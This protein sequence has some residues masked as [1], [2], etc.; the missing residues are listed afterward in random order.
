M[1]INKNM[2]LGM[3]YKA[4]MVSNAI[5]MLY[6]GQPAQT[7]VR[8]D[9]LAKEGFERNV[10]VYRCV[11]ATARSAASIPILLYQKK[12]KELVEI[13]QH[14]LLELLNKPNN[15]ESAIDF[16]EKLIA[17]LLLSGNAYM[18]MNGPNRGAPTELWSWRP[19]RVT[20]VPGGDYIRAFRYS[21]SGKET[22]IPYEKIVHSKFFAPLDDFYGMGP[23]QVARQTI[24][25]DNATAEWNTSLTQNHAAPSGFLKTAS[26]LSEPQYNR[27]KMM[28]RK[29]F[30]GKQNAGKA[31][32][33]EGGLEWQQLGL[34]P[35]DMDFINS[36]KM[37]REEICAVFG[38]PP[39]IVG[40][41]DNSTYSNYQEARTAFYMETV[42]PTLE[43]LISG[44]NHK[45]APLFGDNL[46]ISYDID[47]IEAL[48]EISDTKWT[49]L[50]GMKDILTVNEIREAIGYEAID[51][52]N[53]R[54]VPVGV[55]PEGED[56][57]EAPVI[58]EPADD[59][60]AE[61]DPMKRASAIFTK[62]AADIEQKAS[63]ARYVAEIERRRTGYIKSAENLVKKR[64]IAEQKVVLSAF[65]KDGESGA[66]KAVNQ[67]KREWEK[68]LTAAWLA[69]SEAFAEANYSR[70][71][72]Q[73][74]AKG[75]VHEKKFIFEEEF[76]EILAFMHEY[77]S[78]Q[79]AEA[80]VLISTFSIERLKAVIGDSVAAG[81][82]IQQTA[83]RIEELYSEEFGKARA[84]TIARTE[85]ISAANYGN[86][87][88]AKATGLDLEKKWISVG[89]KRSRDS[90]KTAN[91]QTR[92]MDEPYDIGGA[93]A[94]YPGDPSLPAKE[95]IKC[96]CAER[97]DV[98]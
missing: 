83:K 59:P 31:H 35:K 5:L 48:Q 55:Y 27:L 58:E 33:L 51:G 17:F 75:K 20:I 22:D 53:V 39:Q 86:R 44:W 9:K 81:E 63:D 43:K 64:F 37:T 24:D 13:E 4:S 90:H 25:M 72:E 7:P 8:F 23:I 95:R 30:G 73:A 84:L 28:I 32:L 68:T 26:S 97:H 50:G 71:A 47:R 78:E 11:M 82:T 88:G 52:G 69:A 36:R 14:P 3:Q 46:V 18:E 34:S 98:I 77:I 12:G 16:R 54:Y 92:P 49:R 61:E 57:P 62:A 2:L 76:P 67:Q 87:M 60:A 80:V 45:L 21:V 6:N 41:Q 93:E 79:V 65:N 38:V 66:E 19:D 40:I 94:M 56:A 70:L 15:H 91:G 89:D 29:M 96:R 85:V 10:W 74:K 42:L 1:D